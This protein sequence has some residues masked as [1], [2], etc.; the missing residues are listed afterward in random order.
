MP[1]ILALLIDSPSAAKAASWR[2]VSRRHMLPIALLASLHLAALV[3]LVWSEYAP[4]QRLAFVLTWGLLNCC[5][6][7]LVR[8]PTIAAALSLALVLVLVTLSYFKYKVIWTTANFVDL[9]VID[10][11]TIDYLF[12]V[13]PGLSRIIAA[14]SLVGALLLVLIWRADSFRLRRMP[15]LAGFC[16]CI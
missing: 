11:D 16:F 7:A 4:T 2:A 8:R 13:V 12:T 3:V 5:W 10:T 14:V 1:P 15:A 9:M 6:I